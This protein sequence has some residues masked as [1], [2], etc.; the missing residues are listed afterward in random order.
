MK[1]YVYKIKTIIRYAHVILK[2]KMEAM[3]V[4]NSDN[5]DL[6]Q[7]KKWTQSGHEKSGIKKEGV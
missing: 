4:L 5:Y 7:I 6:I 2:R 3:E 1:L